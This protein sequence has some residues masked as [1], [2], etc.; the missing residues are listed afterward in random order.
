M[1]ATS[2]DRASCLCGPEKHRAVHGIALPFWITNVLGIGTDCLV[3]GT[4]TLSI[5]SFLL[6]LLNF[7]GG[8]TLYVFVRDRRGGSQR[9][10][11]NDHLYLLG[12]WCFQGEWIR[13]G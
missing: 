11:D 13:Q 4:H 3:L 10:I 1:I 12:V 8:V 2:K 5:H 6:A 7:V 9:T